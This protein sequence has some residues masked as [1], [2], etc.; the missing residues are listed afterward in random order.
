MKSSLTFVLPL[1]LASSIF[2]GY[3]RAELILLKGSE[4]GT[5]AQYI[6][7]ETYSTTGDHQPY[8]TAQARAVERVKASLKA[9]CEQDFGGKPAQQIC[10]VSNE[11]EVGAPYGGSY[12]GNEYTAAAEA[13]LLCDAD[14][15]KA[16]YWDALTAQKTEKKQYSGCESLE[17]L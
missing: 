10:I 3:A 15:S 13:A 16:S 6:Y 11:V 17:K 12:A 1:L 8:Q 4:T 9:R 14:L 2:S 7:L 5:A